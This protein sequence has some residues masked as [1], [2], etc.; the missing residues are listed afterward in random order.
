M[1]SSETINKE[2]LLHLTWIYSRMTFVHRERTNVDY[3][4]RFRK[5]I[6]KLNDG[7]FPDMLTRL[8]ETD[9]DAT[10]GVIDAD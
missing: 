6:I 3:M 2:D 9:L 5:I 1:K 7:E 8:L 10:R 4:I